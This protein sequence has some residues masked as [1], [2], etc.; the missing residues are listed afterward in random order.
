VLSRKVASFVEVYGRRIPVSEIRHVTA[1]FGNLRVNGKPVN[2]KRATAVYPK[3]V[4]DYAQAVG[5]DGAAVVT[6]GQAVENRKQRETVLIR[7]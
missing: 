1:T 3:N 2:V 5:R 6:V 4:P 7:K